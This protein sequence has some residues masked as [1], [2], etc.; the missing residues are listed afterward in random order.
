MTRSSLVCLAGVFPPPGSVMGGLTVTLVKM[1]WLVPHLVTRLSSSAEKES[2]LRRVSSVM[3]WRTVEMVMMKQMIFVFV[4]KM[5]MSVSMEEDASGEVGG[6]MEWFSVQTGVTSGT[7]SPS[8][9]KLSKSGSTD[10]N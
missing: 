9:T 4:M 3:E 1:S 8:T 10:S 6:V 2:V 7:V 5:N